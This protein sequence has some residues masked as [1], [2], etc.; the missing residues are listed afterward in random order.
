MKVTGMLLALLVVVLQPGLKAQD[1]EF[2]PRKDFQAEK[3]KITNEIGNLKK[4][5]ARL[6][7]L[8]DS[9][10]ML[11]AASAKEI[12]GLSDSLARVKQDL[13]AMTISVEEN[14][15]KAGAV[16]TWFLIS[17]LFTLVLFT[18]LWILQKRS[19]SALSARMEDTVKAVKDHADHLC[20]EMK[21]VAMG[22]RDT[23][24]RQVEDLQRKLSDAIQTMNTKCQ[25]V[26]NDQAAL[27]GR[28]ET[29]LTELNQSVSAL[30]E[31]LKRTGHEFAQNI[32][33]GSDATAAK[34]G[35]LESELAGLRK[36]LK[37]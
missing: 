14:G 11:T 28:T 26:A 23:T 19:F 30:S 29:R 8:H 31:A 36:L 20:T 10:G 6:V 5:E 35:A 16:M 9:L 37:K 15:R 18:V 33:S 34:L 13:A 24:S 25:S 4:Q 3:R 22:Y 21:A 2:L 12:A 27:D 1:P 32:K 17:I 7:K